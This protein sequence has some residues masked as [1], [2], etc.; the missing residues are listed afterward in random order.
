MKDGWVQ[1]ELD[2]D[3]S[4]KKTKPRRSPRVIDYERIA[5][6]IADREVTKDDIRRM[7]G[8]TEGCINH[9]IDT[10]S[11]QYTLYDIRYNVYKMATPVKRKEK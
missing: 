3:K 2:F 9:V 11:I 7:S 8:I 5:I 6:E 1:L 4:E 10:L